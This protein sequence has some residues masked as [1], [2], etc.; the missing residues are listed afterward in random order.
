[1]RPGRQRCKMQLQTRSRDRFS[2]EFATSMTR[3][4]SMRCVDLP[5]PITIAAQ[6]RRQ[7]ALVTRLNR[8]RPLIP[9]RQRIRETSWCAAGT[10]T[11]RH[12]RRLK[13]RPT[14]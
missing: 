14:P 8:L 6:Q 12:M 10:E 4:T 3:S 1:M 13:A 11:A 5:P 9:E 2:K 7:S